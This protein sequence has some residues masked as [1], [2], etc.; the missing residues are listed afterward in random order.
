[1]KHRKVGYAVEIKKNPQKTGEME[2]NENVSFLRTISQILDEITEG[3]VTDDSNPQITG[4]DVYNFIER[5]RERARLKLEKNKKNNVYDFGE[6][7]LFASIKAYFRF[8]IN[9]DID[10]K[11]C[12][13]EMNLKHSNEEKDF[14]SCL[15]K[16][17]VQS[18]NNP[19]KTKEQKNEEDMAFN[20]FSTLFLH[21]YQNHI[22]KK[23]LAASPTQ[24]GKQQEESQQEKNQQEENQ[25]GEKQ[26]EENQYIPLNDYLKS[27]LI[28]WD[29]LLKG[30]G[31]K[32]YGVYPFCQFVRLDPHLD[33]FGLIIASRLDN[34]YVDSK[35][36][37]IDKIGPIHFIIFN[38]R[39][40]YLFNDHLK[41]SALF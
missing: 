1:M 2:K 20:L 26:Q 16:D 21:I 34:N 30:D 13:T 11:Y 28:T 36:K 4:E 25:P 41:K 18:V 19:E 38:S 5:L 10:R 29:N 8:F 3:S 39:Y 12:S 23:A 27:N 37:E 32:E 24:Q 40:L 15:F 35:V 33:T 17:L 14:L 31:K 9:I 22:K 7:D 6:L